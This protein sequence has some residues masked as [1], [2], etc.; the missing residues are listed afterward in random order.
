MPSL[1][2]NETA[3][4]IADAFASRVTNSKFSKREPNSL[5][6]CGTIFWLSILE[7]LVKPTISMVCEVMENLA[8]DAL[9]TASGN[10]IE[11]NASASQYCLLAETIANR[12]TETAIATYRKRPEHVFEKTLNAIHEIRENKNE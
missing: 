7:Q 5:I 3:K 10:P 8:L 9:F 12:S 1:I 11:K 6:L 4:H 2:S